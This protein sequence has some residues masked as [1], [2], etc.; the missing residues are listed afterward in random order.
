MKPIPC[1][2]RWCIAYAIEGSKHCAVH[3]KFPKFIPRPATKV[4]FPRPP[5]RKKGKRK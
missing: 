3:D 2:I 1:V 5:R 4:F